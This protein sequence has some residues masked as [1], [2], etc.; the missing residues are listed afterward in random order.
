MKRNNGVKIII[1]IVIVSAL[2]LP[3]IINFLYW[4]ITTF[5]P[6]K[7]YSSGLDA[8]VGFY[9]G[10]FGASIT[11][12]GIYWQVSREEKNK[13]VGMINDT[14]AVLTLLYEEAQELKMRAL[15]LTVNTD[16]LLQTVITDIHNRGT[17]HSYIEKSLPEEKV[18][19]ILN[20]NMLHGIFEMFGKEEYKNGYN[21]QPVLDEIAIKTLETITLSFF[22][23]IKNKK[24]NFEKKYG[25]HL[26]L[27]QKENISIS[28]F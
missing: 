7:M 28:I 14:H 16:D 3:F 17:I 5:L 12:T 22:E 26:N 10:F 20:E 2:V 23:K 24:N 25:K 6:G 13:H 18:G 9:G 15:C 19:L 21:L 27:E 1:T 4:V 8:W 11:L